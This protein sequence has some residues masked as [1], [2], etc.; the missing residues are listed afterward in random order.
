MSAVFRTT[1]RVEF[2][3]TDMAGI[4]HFANFFRFMEAAEHEFLRSRGLSVSMDWEGE[5]I[6]FPRVGAS[7]DFHSPV[8]FEDVLDIDF[9]LARVGSK[10]LTFACTFRHEGRLVARGQ[11]ST[12]CCRVQPGQPLESIEVP[13]GIRERLEAK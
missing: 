6:S 10:S 1:R 5:R 3:D 8:R 4:V 9:E 13:A 2:A 11:V 7:C 12:V